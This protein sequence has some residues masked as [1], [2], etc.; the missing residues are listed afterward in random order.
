MS[1]GSG[2]LS[3]QA[4]RL[5]H[6]VRG[7]GGLAGEVADLRDDLESELSPLVALTLDEW[8]DV[9]AADSDGVLLSVVSQAAA[10]SY[11]ASD[12][13]GGAAVELDPPR[14]ITLTCDDSAGTWT[15]NLTATG[16][17]ING[18]AITEDIAFTNNTTTAGAKMFARV[19]SLEADAQ[20]DANGN[21]E[22][23]WGTI[24]GLSK[25]IMSV[26]GALLVAL[27]VEAG[28]VKA[29]DALAGTYADAAT[30]APNGSYDPG[31]APNGTNDYGVVYG[32]D[33]TA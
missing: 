8:V 32:Y 23:G 24:I 13:V 3:T 31:V 27:E 1:N 29:A 4:A 21:W 11:S 25:P 18:D 2:L 9:A 22:V 17:D 5:P 14:N 28:T 30:G 6:L 33:P 12:L 26:A 7:K 20:N 19:D 16:V 15:G 10:A